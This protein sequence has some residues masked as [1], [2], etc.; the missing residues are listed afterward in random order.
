[1]DDEESVLR[2]IL[3]PSHALVVLQ[4]IIFVFVVDQNGKLSDAGGRT[5]YIEDDTGE[6]YTP[7]DN[8]TEED[9]FFDSF[10]TDDTGS[11]FD[12]PDGSQQPDETAPGSTGS[13]ER[14]DTAPST[15][16]IF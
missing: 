12:I 13:S 11:E 7:L 14:R 3:V 1:M 8:E 10:S 5:E 6:I 2:C 15:D 4:E 9:S 16:D